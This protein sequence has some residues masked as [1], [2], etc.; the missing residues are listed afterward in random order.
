[1]KK[2]VVLSFVGLL[3]MALS[4]P[5]HAQIDFKAYGGLFAGF[6]M[7][8]NVTG[9]TPG[10]G[11]TTSF[12]S[13]YRPNDNPATGIGTVP[14]LGDQEDGAWDKWAKFYSS[15]ANIFLEWNAGKEV[16]GVFNIE[17]VNFKSGTNTIRQGPGLAQGPQGL[18]FDTGLWDTRLGQTRLRTA[19]IQFAVPYFGIPVP[20][21]V[22]AGIIPMATRP[23]FIWATT[24]GAGIQIDVKPDPMAFTFTWGKMAEGKDAVAD[25]SNF[26]SLEGRTKMGPATMGGYII[27]QNMNTYPIVYNSTAYGAPSSNFDSE[28]WWLGAYA[29][30]KLGPINLN[31]DFAIDRGKVMGRDSVTVARDVKYRGFAAQAKITYPW[32]KFTF[33]GLLFYASGADQRKTGRAGTPGESVADPGGAPAVSSKVG[34]FVYP[35]GSAQW[36]VWAESMFL[37]GNFASLIAIPQGMAPGGGAWNVQVSRG[38]LGGTWVAKIFASCQPAPWYKATLWALYIGDNTKHGNTLGDAVKGTGRLRDDKTIGWELTLVQDISIYKNLT[39]SFGTGMLFAGD[40]LDQFAGFIDD[41]P[42]NKS[43]KNPYMLS[44]KL[45]YNF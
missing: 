31:L 43:P 7:H 5:V 34:S 10:Q 18:E 22:T 23:A 19:Y 41:I 44:S 28:M 30:T 29:D 36:V 25:D 6:V 1:M 12:P 45:V 8:R 37:G 39:L 9:G 3:I 24:N 4:A 42:I 20:M 14:P 16:K 26:F 21:N 11:I 17:T 40:A 38:A 15:Y 33:G 2:F 13:P 35:V 27:H 32:E